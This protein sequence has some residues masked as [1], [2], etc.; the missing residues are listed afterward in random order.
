MVGHYYTV[1]SVKSI[2]LCL[3]E[4][5]RVVEMDT[6]LPPFSCL[7]MSLEIWVVSDE[8][9]RLNIL[10]T[11]SSRESGGTPCEI[12]DIALEILPRISQIFCDVELFVNFTRLV[13]S[14]VSA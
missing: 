1:T 8:D 6:L 9:P 14:E 10:S 2:V 12:E 7:L 11:K 5:V 4:V 13:V 3:E